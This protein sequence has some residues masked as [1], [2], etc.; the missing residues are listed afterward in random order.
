[1]TVVFNGHR[2]TTPKASVHAGDKQRV[3]YERTLAAV[4]LHCR[5]RRAVPQGALHKAPEHWECLFDAEA[6]LGDCLLGAAELH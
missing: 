5:W 4:P 2:W 1:M 3:S 6:A